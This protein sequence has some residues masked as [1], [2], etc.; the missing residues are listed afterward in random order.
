M[1]RTKWYW[2]CYRLPLVPEWQLN[3]VALPLIVLNSGRRT[4]SGAVRQ[5]MH[6]DGTLIFSY[7]HIK[8]HT[9]CSFETLGQ[10]ITIIWLS[11]LIPKV[12]RE[13]GTISTEMDFGNEYGIPIICI[14]VNYNWR[15][16][17]KISD[18]LCFTWW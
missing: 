12:L 7:E 16:E 4:W 8:I 13:I 6:F 10:E 15:R 14:Y 2:H 5:R 3:D 9:N 11:S 1:V 17:N 18:H